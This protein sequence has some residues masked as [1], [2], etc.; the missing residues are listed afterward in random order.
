MP[1]DRIITVNVETRGTYSDRGQY[2]AGTVTPLRVWATKTDRDLMDVL[3]TGGDRGEIQRTWR[4]RW[5]SRIYA[6]QPE[7]LAVVDDTL[8]FNIQNMAEVTGRDG[9]TRRRFIDLTGVFSA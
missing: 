3:E 1:L 6:A 8:T 7:L 9:M 5:D 4:V 2:V